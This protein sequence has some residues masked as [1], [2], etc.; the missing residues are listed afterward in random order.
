MNKLITAVCIVIIILLLDIIFNISSRIRNEHFYSNPDF[1]YSANSIR[2]KIDGMLINIEI[3]NSAK[4][5][6]KAD[7]TKIDISIP[8]DKD[9][10]Y[11]DYDKDSSEI[12]F[13][14][15]S[16]PNWTLHKINNAENLKV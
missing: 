11:L 2:S 8:I 1:L 5:N 9:G 10:H 13:S 12:S 6:Y 3:S 14:S 16:A 4:N 7:D 15:N